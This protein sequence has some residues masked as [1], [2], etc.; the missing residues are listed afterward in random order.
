MA[1][2]VITRRR[3]ASESLS[4]FSSNG[5]TWTAP[6]DGFII[7]R[8][9]AIVSGA[10]APF[11]V[12]ISRGTSSIQAATAI[13]SGNTGG[14]TYTTS[15]PVKAGEKYYLYIGGFDGVDAIYYSL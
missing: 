8:A 3:M 13:P 15:C 2:T 9:S 1:E 12:Y 11:Y 10:T 6:G 5:D 14:L 4:N 7:A